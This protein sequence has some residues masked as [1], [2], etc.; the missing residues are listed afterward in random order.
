MRATL[1]IYF[2][3]GCNAALAWFLLGS[4]GC[5]HSLKTQ[6]EYMKW[7]NDPANGVVK[8]KH[9]GGF[10]L[11]VK[12]L[13]PSYLLH[14]DISKNI[15]GITPKKKDSLLNVY[16]HS[17]TFIMTLG[18]DAAD[19]NTTS[20]MYAGVKTYKDYVQRDLILNFD[21][22]EFVHIEVGDKKYKPVLAIMENSYELGLKRNIIIAFVPDDKNDN[23]LF[24]A[25]D[26]DFIYDDELFELGLNHFLFRQKDLQSTPE[27]PTLAAN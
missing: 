8:T 10:D 4:M 19:S 2:R 11:K 26:I 7:L 23:V 17:L 24:T 3:M 15:A 22:K 27:F 21:F 18:P 13:P 14:Q 12:F 5:T 16:Q 1:Q 6:G 25:S 20:I 9:I